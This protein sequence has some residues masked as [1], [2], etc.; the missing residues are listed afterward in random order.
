MTVLVTG[1][2]GTVGRQ[3]VRH[4]LDRGRKV[5]A[6][7][8]DPDRAVLPYGVEVAAGDLTDAAGL[9]AAFDG[10]TA[11]HLINFGVGYRPLTN[12]RDIVALAERAGVGKTTVLGGWQEGT[13]EPA[14]RAMGEVGKIL[15]RPARTY[16]DWVADHIAALRHG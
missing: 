12:G 10:V 3:V 7:T 16:G 14:V 1:A 9:E 4:L 15:G 11:V 6:L 13:L 8:R 5:R 2:T